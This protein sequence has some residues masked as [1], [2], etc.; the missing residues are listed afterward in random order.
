MKLL[1][2]L[3]YLMTR[4]DWFRRYLKTG[5]LAFLYASRLTVP[6]LRVAQLDRYSLVVNIAEALGVCAYFLHDPSVPWY[7]DRLVRDGDC[8]LDIGSNMGH[9]AAFMA[10]HVGPRG[11][12]VAFEPQPLYAGLIG[13]TV[14]ANHWGD[15]LTLV[16][17]ATAAESGKQLKFFLSTNVH[18]SGVA[19]L[20]NHGTWLDEDNTI[21]VET[22]TL[23][24]W[25]EANQIGRVRFAKL[26]VERAEELVLRGATQLLAMQAVDVWWIEMV[27]GSA[28]ATLMQNAGYAGFGLDGHGPA[29][30]LD[31]MAKGTTTD[32]LFLPHARIGEFNW[33]LEGK[34]VG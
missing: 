16:R 5:R 4:T 24:E 17:E 20:V 33:I 1:E 10:N 12:V 23:D 25:A 13:E 21:S 6:T 34:P 31:A 18:N 7:L 19:S 8:C 28:C 9:Y 22:I 11:R 3:I 2:T 26:D 14:V 15:R 30:P 27:T 32:I 29:T